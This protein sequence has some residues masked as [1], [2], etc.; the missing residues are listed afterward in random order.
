MSTNQHPAKESKRPLC[1]Q[2]SASKHPAKT[3]APAP[4]PPVEGQDGFGSGHVHEQRKKVYI[5][6]DQPDSTKR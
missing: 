5:E 6:R 3:N 2:H 4:T 1:P